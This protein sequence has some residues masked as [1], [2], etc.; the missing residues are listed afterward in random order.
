V[1]PKAVSQHRQSLVI[2]SKPG[3]ALSTSSP[4]STVHRSDWFKSS[5]TREFE[6]RSGRRALHAQLLRE[7][8]TAEHD[9]GRARKAIV[10]AGPPGAGKST[11]RRSILGDSEA[12]YLV[13]DADEFK[14][15]LLRQALQDGTYESVLKPPQVKTLEDQGEP[16]F[17]MELAALV[18]EES[19]IL[20]TRL[21]DESIDEGRNIIIDTV[22]SSEPAALKLMRQLDQAGYR[23]E[24]IDVEV[25]YNISAARIAQR[26]QH[27][28]EQALTGQTTDVPGGRWVPSEYGHAVFNGPQGTS[29]PETNARLCAQQCPAVT[30]Y[31]LYRTIPQPDSPTAGTS[32]LETE[33]RRH[34]H[35]TPLLTRARAR[36]DRT[37]TP[38]KPRQTTPEPQH[39]IGRT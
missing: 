22:L 4:Y 39:G 30:R 11:L 9:P 29:W 32:I 35:G 33:L 3:G 37:P 8:R 20:A 28:Y 18:H 2:L 25:P 34:N 10:M 15:S 16:F 24:I 27:G 6:A 17:P 12:D 5:K 26:W 13:I 38:A 36:T 23:I 1:D 31:R 14:V 19:S 7:Q 21:R